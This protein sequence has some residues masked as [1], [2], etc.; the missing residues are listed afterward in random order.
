MKQQD[1]IVLTLDREEIC[2]L[3]SVLYDFEV[4]VNLINEAKN[5]Y[6]SKRS[7]IADYYTYSEITELRNSV[8]GYCYFDT[9]DQEEILEKLKLI[10][11]KDSDSAFNFF[12]EYF[13]EKFEDEN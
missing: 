10:Y 4:L 1:K 13:Q 3:E 5:L 2:L 9:V 6:P 12:R 7:G 8:G 11:E